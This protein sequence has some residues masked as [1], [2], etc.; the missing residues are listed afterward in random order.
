MPTKNIVSTVEPPAFSG[1]DRALAAELSDLLRQHRPHCLD[2]VKF[3]EPPP[4][5]SMPLAEW[6]QPAVFNP[7]VQRYGDDLYRDYPDSQREGKPLQSL[8]A[9][10]YFGLLV[11]PLMLV[12]LKHAAVLDCSPNQ[13]HVGF[14]H[15]GH[16]ATFYIATRALPSASAGDSPRAR[17]ERLL[18]QHIAPVINT[19]DSFGELNARLAWNNTGYLM[20]WFLGEMKALMP[21][22]ELTRLSNDLFFSRSLLDGGENPLYRTVIP[23]SGIIQRRSCCQ[24]YRIPG[25][26]RCQDCT[27][28]KV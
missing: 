18:H 9:Q 22:D 27:L 1:G 15:K 11:P 12:L 7:L 6:S 10:W 4:A 24:R 20:Y 5:G 28:N 26:M 14:H 23:R 16:P 17:L 21:Q 8:W 13:I 19:L 2:S 25:V 3:G